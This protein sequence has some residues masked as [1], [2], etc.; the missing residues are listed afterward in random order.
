LSA[1]ALASAVTAAGQDQVEK[2]AVPAIKA[3]KWIGR[4]VIRQC[5]SDRC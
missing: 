3:E 1:I 2:Q 4:F 5:G